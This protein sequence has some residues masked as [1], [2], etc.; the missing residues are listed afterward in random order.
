MVPVLPP[1]SWSTVDL[2]TNDVVPCSLSSVHSANG[3]LSS[4]QSSIGSSSS[5]QESVAC[6]DSAHTNTNRLS[7]RSLSASA[8]PSGRVVMDD[9][10]TCSSETIEKRWQALGK[11]ASN[12]STANLSSSVHFMHVS[13]FLNTQP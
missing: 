4:S 5:P 12:Q 13:D 6:D 8:G 11:A 10:S 2:A 9:N 7:P 3:A 1:P